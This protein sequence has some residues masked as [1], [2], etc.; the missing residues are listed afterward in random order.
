MPGQEGGRHWV[1]VW[2]C[3]KYI[4]SFNV[5]DENESV[6]FNVGPLLQIT[7]GL[8]VQHLALLVKARGKRAKISKETADILSQEAYGHIFP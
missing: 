8:D 5:Q 3:V 4:R 6:N 1:Y 2:K 7:T